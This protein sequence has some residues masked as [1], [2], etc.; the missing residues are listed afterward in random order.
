MSTLDT[1][2]GSTLP[3][4]IVSSSNHLGVGRINHQHVDRMVKPTNSMNAFI[5]FIDLHHP[6]NSDII[7]PTCFYNSVR[8]LLAGAF[9]DKS[10]LPRSIE[11][12][13]RCTEYCEDYSRTLFSFS[14]NPLSAP[15]RNRSQILVSYKPCETREDE[16]MHCHH[17]GIGP[18]RF[19]HIYLI[20]W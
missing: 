8:F 15:K 16:G 20:P 17:I 3:A 5:P 4:I 6:D 9:S 12:P 7:L 13:P 2:I 1:A 19:K 11:R 10:V 18:Q 14:P